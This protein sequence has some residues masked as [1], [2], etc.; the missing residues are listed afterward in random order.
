MGLERVFGEAR[1]PLLH[2]IS[3]AGNSVGSS[4]LTLLCANVV[5]AKRTTG[6]CRKSR[7][8]LVALRLT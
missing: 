4:I 3:T 1:V 2:I 5:G 8:F 7:R 6:P